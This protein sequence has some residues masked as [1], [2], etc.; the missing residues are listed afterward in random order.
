MKIQRL[1]KIITLITF[2]L[3]PIIINYLSPYLIV[4]GASEGIING[5]FVV[6]LFLFLSSLVLG[7]GFC[8]W[9]CPAACLQEVAFGV[10]NKPVGGRANWIKYIIW[11]PWMAAILGL[12]F[13]AGGFKRVDI[14]Y[15]TERI[16]SVD[17]PEK[18]V[19]YYG[20]I[21][22]FVLM[23][24]IVGKRAAC[25]SICWMAPFMI[26]GRKLGSLIKLPSLHLRVAEE[27]CVNC[28][29]CTKK[30]PMSLEVHRM[31]SRGEI[32]S[33]ECILCGECVEVCSKKV[34]VFSFGQKNKQDK[35]KMEGV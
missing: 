11:F 3:F 28:T 4:M 27:R 25:H 35:E 1:R 5:S 21:G 34:I 33:S 32:D 10:N 31:V 6:F 24:F 9:V 17:G 13:A 22:I 26:Y 7:R 15:M 2:L 20:V 19:I 30:C 29:Q 12:G 18:F 14:L 16:I 8:G 23:A